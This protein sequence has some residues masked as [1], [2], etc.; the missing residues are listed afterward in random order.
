MAELILSCGLEGGGFDL[1]TLTENDV[2]LFY[3]SGS[4]MYLDENDDEAWRSW[5]SEKVAGW[6]NALQ[7]LQQYQ[8]WI[9]IP[10]YI[11]PAY[12]A[13][14]LAAVLAQENIRSTD[15]RERWVQHCQ[16]EADK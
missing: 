8:W 15:V 4:A 14:V 12:R 6:E 2:T 11:H 3:V 9:T 5:E 7:L 13:N 16:P 10:T 1:Y